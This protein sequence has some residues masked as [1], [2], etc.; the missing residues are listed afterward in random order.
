MTKAA[1][2]LMEHVLYLV[3]EEVRLK[4]EN[5]PERLYKVSGRIFSPR[6]AERN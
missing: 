3:V 4:P 5:L 6:L 2:F 1:L